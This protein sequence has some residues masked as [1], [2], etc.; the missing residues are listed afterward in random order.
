MDLLKLS[1]E[2]ARAELFSA[3]IVWL[4][5]LIT[6][7]SAVGFSVWGKTAMAKAFVIPLAIAGVLFIVIGIGLYAANKPRIAQFEQEQRTDRAAFI[8]KEIARTTKS[9]QDFVLVF[10]VLPGLAVLAAAAL[11]IAHAPVWRAAALV[12]LLVVVF[13]MLVDSNTAARNEAYRQELLNSK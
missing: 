1:T 9:N 13:L 2:W 5:S 4:F 8:T 11:L 3:K 12:T 10:K 7:I 6:L